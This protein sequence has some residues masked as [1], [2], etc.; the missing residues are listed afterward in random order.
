MMLLVCS[1]LYL[2]WLAISASLNLRDLGT[3]PFF[4]AAAFQCVQFD[5]IDF[6]CHNE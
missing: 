6:F 5:N 1:R 2:R 3:R 4:G